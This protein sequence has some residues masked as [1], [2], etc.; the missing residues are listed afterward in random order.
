M[1]WSRSYTTLSEIPAE[2][3]QSFLT[4]SE[5][6]R[7]ST[8]PYNELKR[9]ITVGEIEVLMTGKTLIRPLIRVDRLRAW[10]NANT[11][12]FGSERPEK[13][14][15]RRTVAYVPATKA[16]YRKMLRAAAFGES[17][18]KSVSQES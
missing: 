14:R 11:V 17:T 2:H 16:E 5:S 15:H 7:L 12:Q 13:P 6:A 9:V 8:V 10:I 1:T 3:K 4:L 18:S